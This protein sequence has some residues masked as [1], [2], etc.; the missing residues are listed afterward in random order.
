[1]H[2]SNELTQL[3]IALLTNS[4]IYE[5]TLRDTKCFELFDV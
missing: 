4:K 2:H 5:I 1:M 3:T